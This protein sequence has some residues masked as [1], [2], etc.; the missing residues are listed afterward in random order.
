V[1]SAI[2]AST[3]AMKWSYVAVRASASSSQNT[4]APSLPRSDRWMWQEL[5]SRS[6]YFAMNV[7]DLPCAAAISLAAVL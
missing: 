1:K 2:V 3:P 7:T 4:V 6:L 5:P